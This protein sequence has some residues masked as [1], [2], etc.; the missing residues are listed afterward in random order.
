MNGK[1]SIIK[2]GPAEA[3]EL[4][5]GKDYHII[6]SQILVILDLCVGTAVLVFFTDH[7]FIQVGPQL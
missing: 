5:F 4:E 1:I 2:L 3:Q 7:K 6:K